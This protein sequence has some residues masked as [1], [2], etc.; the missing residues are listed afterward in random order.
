[1]DEWA[2]DYWANNPSTDF[3]ESESENDSV[4]NDSDD[5]GNSEDDN[6]PLARL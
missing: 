3:D 2:Y 4:F 1:M 5:V 6:V